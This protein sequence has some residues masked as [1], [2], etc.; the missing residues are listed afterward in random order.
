MERDDVVAELASLAVAAHRIASAVCSEACDQEGDTVRSLAEAVAEMSEQVA[1]LASASDRVASAVCSPAGENYDAAGVLVGS[2]TE[3]VMGVT[4]ALVK[5][6]ECEN[7]S[8]VGSSL[9]LMSNSIQEAGNS[10]YLGLELVADAIR[11]S[12]AS[13]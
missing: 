2:L 6:S 3:A 12:A 5:I 7:L 13:G 9:Y 1:A 8:E 10:V 4:A 11:A